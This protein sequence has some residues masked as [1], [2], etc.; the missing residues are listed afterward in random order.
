MHFSLRKSN[1]VPVWRINGDRHSG[2]RGAVEATMKNGA[3][4]L[5][6][7]LVHLK[8]NV[9]TRVVLCNTKQ[10]LADAFID[11]L[12]CADTTVQVDE[13]FGRVVQYNNLQ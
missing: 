5:Y 7:D 9:H 3:D 11:E 10:R 13:I 8:H 12:A 1:R 6:N 2:L 4:I